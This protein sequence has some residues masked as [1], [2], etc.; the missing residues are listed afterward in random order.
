MIV[1][2]S[3]AWIAY[4]RDPTGEMASVLENA[5]TQERVLMLDIVLLEVLQGAVSEAHAVRL[6]ENLNLLPIESALDPSLA[7]MAARNY[8]TLRAAGFT[9]RKTVD[10]IIGTY[11]I[12]HRHTLLHADRDFAP[13]VQ[14]L[15]LT[16]I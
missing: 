11:C 12:E 5:V 14:H 15:G 2:D 8:R 10:L 4:L 3:S 1:A 16:I 6:A 13:M 7:R 9:I